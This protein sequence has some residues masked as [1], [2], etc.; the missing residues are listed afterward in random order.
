MWK[1]TRK[2]QSQ[3]PLNQELD[4]QSVWN[5]LE[6]S[7]NQLNLFVLKQEK[8]LEGGAILDFLFL[9]L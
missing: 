2:I 4:Q 7:N 5:H 8:K 9:T 1:S 6:I 3:T